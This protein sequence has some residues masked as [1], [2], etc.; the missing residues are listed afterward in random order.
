MAYIVKRP[1]K[2]GNTIMVILPIF[3]LEGC[4]QVVDDQTEELEIEME[5]TKEVLEDETKAVVNSMRQDL[6]ETADQVYEMFVA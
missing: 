2:E 3:L 5:Q 4:S 1:T 6:S